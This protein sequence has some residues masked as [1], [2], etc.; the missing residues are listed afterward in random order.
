MLSIFPLYE[1]T[2]SPRGL[3]ACGSSDTMISWLFWRWTR[4]RIV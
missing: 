4:D 3:D 2:Y 1:T